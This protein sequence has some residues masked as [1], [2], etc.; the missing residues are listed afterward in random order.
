MRPRTNRKP[1][2]PSSAETIITDSFI[3]LASLVLTEPRINRNQMVEVSRLLKN[4]K[5]WIDYA[6]KKGRRK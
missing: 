2:R 1:L 4:M 6:A 3:L 5:P